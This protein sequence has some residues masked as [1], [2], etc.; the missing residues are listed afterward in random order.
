M[1]TIQ[2]GVRKIGKNAR[3]VLSLKELGGG[4]YRR[5]EGRQGQGWEE[6]T[7]RFLSAL[8]ARERVYVAVNEIF[9]RPNSGS[10]ILL[11]LLGQCSSLRLPP[12]LSSG[13]TQAG[14]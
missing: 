12:V 4:S 13:P 10:Q 14:V 1:G 5:N 3:C 7:I 2:E 6:T 8:N 9:T 11:S